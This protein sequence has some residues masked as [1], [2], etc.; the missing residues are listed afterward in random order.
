VETIKE[1]YSNDWKGVPLEQIPESYRAQAEARRR[2]AAGPGTVGTELAEEVSKGGTTRTAIDGLIE[3]GAFCVGDPKRVLD[4]VRKYV[5]V[6]GDRI[7]SIMQMA[8]IPHDDIMRSIELFGSK[9]IPEIRKDEKSA[10]ST[11]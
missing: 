4:N 8:D 2:G 3:T 7:V 6:G 5:E 10:E 1:I 11:S 9:V